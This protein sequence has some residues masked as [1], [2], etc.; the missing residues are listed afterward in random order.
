ME[1]TIQALGGLI[2]NALPTLALVIL[3]HFYLKWMFF[4]PI[5]Q[6]LKA[7]Y[8]AT[9]GAVKLAQEAVAKADRKTAEF[10]EALR[11]ARAGIYREQEQ[12]RLAWREQQAS[13]LRRVREEAT[14]RLRQAKAEIEST[15]AGERANLAAQTDALAAQIFQRITE[16][17]AA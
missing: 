8:E 17:K 4:K 12:A 9:Q 13:E 3:L 16:G 10:E 7:R 14:A 6:V 15:A 11:Q 1:A 5:D 2:I